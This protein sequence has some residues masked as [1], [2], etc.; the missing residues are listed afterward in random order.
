MYLKMKQLIVTFTVKCDY[1]YQIKMVA[2]LN[3]YS[4]M[5]CFLDNISKKLKPL[6]SFFKFYSLMKRI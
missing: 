6:S 1:I 3:T 5:L 2:F 4:F